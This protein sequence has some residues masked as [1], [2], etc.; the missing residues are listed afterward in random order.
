MP[1]NPCPY[2]KGGYCI[3][4]LLD[5]PTDSVV[6]SLRC[7]NIERAKTCRYYV[8][9][10]EKKEGLDSFSEIEKPKLG[11][12]K[13]N[14]ITKELLQKID[15]VGCEFFRYNNVEEGII[16]YCRLK[17]RVL[18]ESEAKNCIL[19]YDKCPIRKVV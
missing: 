12:L 16:A 18:T 15:D 3:S 6:S 4:P 17:H 14:L 1:N 2:Y 5:T 19:Y 10:E 9:K 11:Y 8:E 13:I 7:L